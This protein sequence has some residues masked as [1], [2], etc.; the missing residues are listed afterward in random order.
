MGFFELDDVFGYQEANGMRILWAADS[1][2]ADAGEG[3]I[4]LDTAVS[5]CRI[6]R[7]ANSL[8]ETVCAVPSGTV[9]PTPSPLYGDAM[10]GE[11][12][13]DTSTT[14]PVLKRYNGTAWE[15]AVVYSCI[16]KD[17]DDSFSG[18]LTSTIAS[19]AAMKFQS[20]DSNV[21]IHDGY[22]NINYR[23]GVGDDNIVTTVNGACRFYQN[24]TGSQYLL[25]T[26]AAVGEA[27]TNDVYILV[28]SSGIYLYGTAV[29]EDE[30]LI[31]TSTPANVENGSLW[32]E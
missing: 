2:P 1:P 13:L 16:R 29:V 20:V 27:F 31:P 12:F 23:C 8:W 3:E 26:N 5:P 4:W 9:A 14:P 19:M 6:K 18:T 11:L 7:Y 21:S 30:I 15:N 32:I 24:H 10:E 28:S 22:G 25:A 17:E